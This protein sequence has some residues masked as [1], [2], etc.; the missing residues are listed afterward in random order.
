MLLHIITDTHMEHGAMCKI[1]IP[2]GIKL[3]MFISYNG[4][5]Q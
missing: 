5:F 2:D 1:K 4:T 3:T